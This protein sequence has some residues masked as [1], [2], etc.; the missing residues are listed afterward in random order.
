[1]SATYHEGEIAVQERAGTRAMADKIGRGIDA[2]IPPVAAAFLRSQRLAL[3]AT[4]D[5]DGLVWLSPLAGAPGFVRALDERTL[6]IDAALLPRDPMAASLP[7]PT[8][9]GVV[10][11]DLTNRRRLRVNGTLVQTDGGVV[12]HTEQVFWNCPKYIQQRT[13]AQGPCAADPGRPR[14]HHPERC[15]AAVDRAGRHLLHRQHPPR[16]RPRRLAPR[17]QA[18]VR[19]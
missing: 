4:V 9:A 7:G 13:P 19:P 15:A 2:A 17:R 18:G 8:V 1:M 16:A 11:I 6:R 5:P 12:V 10:V 3:V 14:G